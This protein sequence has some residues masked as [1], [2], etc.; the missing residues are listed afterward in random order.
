MA[1]ALWLTDAPPSVFETESQPGSGP[2]GV[3]SCPT[4]GASL[5]VVE[6]YDLCVSEGVERVCREYGGLNRFGEPNFR[7]VWGWRRLMLLEGVWRRAVPAAVIVKGI[8][9][10]MMDTETVFVGAKWVQKYPTLNNFFIMERWMP[11]EHYGTKGAWY[12]LNTKADPETGEVFLEGGPYPS[13]G[14]YEMIWHFHNPWTKGFEQ[15]T[16]NMAIDRI[17]WNQARQARTP[18]DVRKE[19]NFHNDYERK[20]ADQRADDAHEKNVAAF[21]MKPWVPTTGA[22]PSLMPGWHR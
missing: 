6:Q 4:S 5:K 22:L 7:I 14:D 13:R 20:L 12:D 15:V 9:Q 18:G 10:H 21:P 17:R 2:G 11:P 19:C 1:E 8:P 3:D 16:E